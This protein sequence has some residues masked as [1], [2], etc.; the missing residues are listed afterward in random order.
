MNNKPESKE[1]ICSAMDQMGVAVTILDP[2]GILLYYNEHAASVLDRTAEYLGTEV[3]EYHKKA[4]S[5]EKIKR[6]IHAFQ[7][8]RNA[9]FRYKATPYGKSIFVTVSPIF[10]QGIFKGCVQSV[11]LEDEL[12]FD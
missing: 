9:P 12:Q 4:E 6:M 5:N 10:E 7:N 8:G 11:V 2:N 1:L 3:F